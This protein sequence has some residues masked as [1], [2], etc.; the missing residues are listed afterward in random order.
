MP[1]RPDWSK[2]LPGSERHSLEDLS[3]L[4]VR[5]GSPV[6]YDRRGEVIWFDDCRYGLAP[7]RVGEVGDDAEVSV[8]VDQT[9]ASP[10]AIKLTGG[11]SEG[12]TVAIYKDYTKE[13]LNRV[14]VEFSFI[15]LSIFDLIYLNILAKDGELT[16]WGQVRLTYSTGTWAYI[17][18]NSKY[19]DIASPGI[20]VGSWE[21]YHRIK[22][23]IDLPENKYVRFQYDNNEYDLST[24]PLV[25]WDEP[26]TPRYIIDLAMVSRENYNDVIQ[27]GRCIITGNEP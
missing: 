14:G 6:T 22:L 5:L 25:S 24:Y 16:Q 26:I 23:V 21:F 13:V 20:V 8:V 18:N 11:S 12:N 17:D 27:V 2:Y 15:A 4:A 9:D 3:E 7:W 1:D 10:Y 19:Q